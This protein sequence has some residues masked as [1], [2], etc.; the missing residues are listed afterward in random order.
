MKDYKCDGCGGNMLFDP[1]RQIIACEYC[2]R[3][4][5][6][7]APIQEKRVRIPYNVDLRYEGYKDAKRLFE[8]GNCKTRIASCLDAPIT[9]CPSCGSADIFESQAD[10][11]HPMN[12]IPFSVS[13][14]RASEFFNKWIKSRKFAPN[15]LKKMAK[16]QKISGMYAP[17]Y[18]FD[19]DAHTDYSATCETVHTSTDR[20]GR[21]H[22]HTHS[23]F[24]NSSED[25]HFD[26]YCWSANETLPSYIVDKMKGYDLDGAKG[27]VSDYMLGFVGIGT[28]MDV[29]KAKEQTVES[30]T[31]A[32][33]RRIKNKLNVRYDRVT[34]FKAKTAITNI[35]N[36]Y[37]YVPVW[38]NHYRYKNKDYHCY[39]NGQTG[40]VY[41][42]APKSFW[43]IFF[44][45]LGMVG[46]TA[47][48]AWLF[49]NFR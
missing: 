45:V 41:G 17:V 2:E 12:I 9:R 24:V 1:E 6:I 20:N 47:L 10:G 4:E 11:S 38:A 31:N 40:A 28:N 29:H 42:K 8:C 19:L 46:A 27:Y 43:K 14:N 21:K 49:S 5:E 18:L 35:F 16:L 7:G 13:K 23:T 15:D 22:S 26:N 48:L 25:K 30:V 32:E 3:T 36:T 37:C 33:H 39:I 44:F 34:F